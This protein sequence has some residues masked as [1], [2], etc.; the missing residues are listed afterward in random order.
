MNL[1]KY[2]AR[3]GV[4]F[5]KRFLS[6]SNKGCLSKVDPPGCRAANNVRSMGQ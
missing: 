6:R 2:D 1:A 5:V 4:V 3:Y